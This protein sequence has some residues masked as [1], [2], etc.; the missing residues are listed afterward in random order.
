MGKPMSSNFKNSAFKK[1]HKKYKRRFNL[2]YFKG[3]TKRP[4]TLILLAKLLTYTKKLIRAFCTH[5]VFSLLKGIQ[6]QESG[7]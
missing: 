5:F 6:I 2:G 3:H 7:A 4:T 1:V